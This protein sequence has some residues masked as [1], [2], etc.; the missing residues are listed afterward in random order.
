MS[1]GGGGDDDIEDKLDD[2]V[3]EIRE[4]TSLM[5]FALTQGDEEFE[6]G[7]EDTGPIDLWDQGTSVAVSSVDEFKKWRRRAANEEGVST[8][9]F[10]TDELENYSSKM[11]AHVDLYIKGYQNLQELRSTLGSGGF[12][13]FV[14]EF[15]KRSSDPSVGGS[16]AISSELVDILE[17]SPSLFGIEVIEDEIRINP[18]L[19]PFNF[20]DSYGFIWHA[21]GKPDER[22]S[23]GAP[24]NA[25]PIVGSV[26]SRDMNAK[27]AKIID[28]TRGMSLPDRYKDLL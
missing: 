5:R 24:D 26:T 18:S 8:P 27:M 14:I 17:P 19:T 1:I 10:N 23:L 13:E 7:E 12:E 21:A 4:L 22:L 9:Y 2:L 28:D 3:D 16:G 11:D 20:I 15:A 6:Q 25:I